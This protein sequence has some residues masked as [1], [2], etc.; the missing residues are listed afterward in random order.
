M[1]KAIILVCSIISA[2]QLRD[3]GTDNAVQ[4][5]R[6]PDEFLLPSQCFLRAQAYYAETEFGRHLGTDERIRF[7]CT[8]QSHPNVG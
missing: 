2:P 3:C 6:V 5:L 1:F 8:R 7:V 4:V